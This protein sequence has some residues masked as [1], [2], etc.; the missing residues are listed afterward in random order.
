MEALEDARLDGGEAGSHQRQGVDGEMGILGER[1]AVVLHPARHVEGAVAPFGF[2]DFLKRRL[3][4]R[5]F[6]NSASSM[7]R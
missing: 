2:A 3:V 1:C 6:E 5:R 7:G 4:A